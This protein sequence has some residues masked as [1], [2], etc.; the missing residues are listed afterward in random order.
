M[1]IKIAADLKQVCVSDAALA[2][3]AEKFYLLAANN[4]QKF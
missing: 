2:G 4:F 3:I 1:N